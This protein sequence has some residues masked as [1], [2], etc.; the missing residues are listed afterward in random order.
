M[1]TLAKTQRILRDG[2]INV[3]WPN[4]DRRSDGWIG[5]ASHEATGAP[6]SGGSDHNPNKR[7]TVNAIDIDRNGIHIP[8]VIASML[9]H[10]STRYV[11]FNRKI[12][13][14][15]DGFVPHDYTGK[16]QHTGHIHRSV[17]QSATAENRVTSY[18]FI[19][20]PMSWPLL[21]RGASG[22]AVGELQAY[23]IG[24]GYNLRID[25]DFGPAT[26]KAVKAFQAYRGI[27]ADGEVG[28][29]TRGKLRPFK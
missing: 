1:A 8:T 4:R 27:A 3:K 23:L 21:K 22:V 25:L 17:Y 10:P 5:D 12:M 16:N 14:S 15:R 6:E 13:S 20:A 7:D 11:I 19:L 2:N 29:V 26:E 9:M 28:P 18:R 24:Y